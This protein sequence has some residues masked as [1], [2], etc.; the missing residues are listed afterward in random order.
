MTRVMLMHF[1]PPL[2][3]EQIK[4]NKN[5]KRKKGR[6][7]EKWELRLNWKKKKKEDG[8]GGKEHSSTIA[9]SELS[10]CWVL[11]VGVST[12]TSMAKLT[13]LDSVLKIKTNYKI[14]GKFY[15]QY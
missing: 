2:Q 3:T 5:L 15:Q 7:K 6:K 9:V 12:G 14:N 1:P 4:K 11:L 8:N 10:N 13:I